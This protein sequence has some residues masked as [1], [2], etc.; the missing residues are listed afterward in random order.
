M[1]FPIQSSEKMSL[2]PVI[3]MLLQ[4]SPKELA[5]VQ[6]ANLTPSWVS[7]PVKEVKKINYPPLAP[8][9][10]CSNNN[11][12]ISSTGLRPSGV[13]VSGT[14]VSTPLTGKSGGGLRKLSDTEGTLSSSENLAD[15]SISFSHSKDKSSSMDESDGLG[16]NGSGRN[17]IR[18]EHKGSLNESD[19]Q[20]DDHIE[21]HQKAL[22]LTKNPNSISHSI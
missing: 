1:T 2:V 13:S 4:F 12:N 14:G 22:L 10:S 11:N 17:G 18:L 9:P 20:L 19:L 3:A 6:Q 15:I 5:E 7:R 16:V 21:Q 8:S